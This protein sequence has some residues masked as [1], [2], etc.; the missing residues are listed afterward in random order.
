MFCS[1]CGSELLLEARYR[2]MRLLGQGGCG[3]TFEVSDR[4]G[5]PKVLKILINNH[6]K[7]VEL[8]Q[9]EALVLSQ[10]NHPG[11]PLVESDAYFTLSP[12][13]STP[14]IALPGNGKNRG[15]GFV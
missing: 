12:K 14:A 9:R 11:I 3:K 7:Y 10:L 13:K 2:V 8:F 5:T 6:P 1:S 4:D 15:Y